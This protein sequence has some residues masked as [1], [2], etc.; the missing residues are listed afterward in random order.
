MMH[1]Q[2]RHI[3]KGTRDDV[4]EQFHKNLNLI[5]GRATHYAM[6][7]R[8]FSVPSKERI[9][10]CTTMLWAY[11]REVYFAAGDYGGIIV[12]FHDQEVLRW[13]G[14]LLIGFLGLRDVEA[15]AFD[16]GRM[17]PA[18]RDNKEAAGYHACRI[19]HGLPFDNMMSWDVSNIMSCC[20]LEE[21]FILTTVEPS[22]WSVSATKK[23]DVVDLRSKMQGTF[24]LKDSL[25]RI[26]R[27]N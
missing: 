19:I 27:G 1:D 25:E 7:N 6:L 21:S 15:R 2:M 20:D 18:M 23:G 3:L 12:V 24:D 4:D 26:K 16:A 22:K 8:S 5:L 13:F 11:Y 14:N 9:Q 10:V 17:C